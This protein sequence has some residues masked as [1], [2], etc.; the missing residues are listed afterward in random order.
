MTG[1]QCCLRGHTTCRISCLDQPCPVGGA[2]LP[3]WPLWPLWPSATV[4]QERYPATPWRAGVA[5]VDLN[6]Q[7]ELAARPLHIKDDHRR[8]TRRHTGRSLPSNRMMTP[9]SLPS[10]PCGGCSGE[11]QLDHRTDRPDAVG[12][13]KHD[14]AEIEVVIDEVQEQLPSDSG[15]SSRVLPQPERQL[16]PRRCRSPARPTCPIQ[17]WRGLLSDCGMTGS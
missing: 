12:H 9:T 1:R 16:H 15:I 6:R 5:L 13:L 3:G 4:G 8:L 7:F 2:D 14:P 10:R 11:Q 17:T